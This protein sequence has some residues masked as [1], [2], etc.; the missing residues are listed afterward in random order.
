MP[1]RQ[2]IPIKSFSVTAYICRVDNGVGRFLLIRRCTPYLHGTWQM[3][4]GKIEKGEKAWEAALREIREETGLIPD[5]L[6][7]TNELEMFYE[8]GQNCINI[9]PIF[10]GFIDS[11]QKVTLSPEHDNFRWVTSDDACE[12]LSF[13]H[14]KQTVKRLE[15]MFVNAEPQEF[16]LIDIS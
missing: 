3:V 11:E 5:R 2:E 4:S 8:V 1:H 7:S 6:Y 14:Q 16:L 9:V 13:D 15:A 10:L 12:L